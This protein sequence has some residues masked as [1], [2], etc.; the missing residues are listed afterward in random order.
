SRG[1]RVVRPEKLER[2][3]RRSARPGPPGRRG[4]ARLGLGPEPQPGALPQGG[5]QGRQADPP[6]VEPEDALVPGRPGPGEGG[7]ALGDRPALRGGHRPADRPALAPPPCRALP[8][9][10]WRGALP[11]PDATASARL[12]PEAGPA[13][14]GEDDLVR[15]QRLVGP[16]LP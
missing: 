1:R 2:C 16:R 7:I 5:E 11:E 9:R 3:P 12:W 14:S 10:P 15:R 6:L 4:A 13:Q 8:L